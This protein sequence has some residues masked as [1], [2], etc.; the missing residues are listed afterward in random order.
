MSRKLLLTGGAGDLG[1]VLSKKLDRRGDDVLLL[2]VRIPGDDFG[3]YVEAS[4]LDR[5]NLTRYLSGIDVVVHIAAWHGVHEA[6]GWK[7][8]K[9]IWE[10]NIDGTFNV[11][12]ACEEAGVD[13]VVYI[14]N[15]SVKDR[16]GIYGFTKRMGEA[17]AQEY[18]QQ[19]DM[20][21]IILRPRAFSR[22]GTGRYTIRSWS[23]HSGFGEVQFI[24]MMWPKP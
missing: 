3:N 22:I 1:Q 15:T 6:L 9:E 19:H 13:K 21:V 23:G 8:R 2:D 7:S 10:L 16:E 14:S 18:A 12:Q 4:I 17:I 11:F 20:D 24:L 5:N